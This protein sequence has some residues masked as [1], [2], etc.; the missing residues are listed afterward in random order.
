[1]NE[2]LLADLDELDESEEDSG[3]MANEQL[4]EEYMVVPSEG[5]A[6]LN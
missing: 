6:L 1:M 5:S 2:E 3:Q 4:R